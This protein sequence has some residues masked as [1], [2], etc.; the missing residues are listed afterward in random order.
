MTTFNHVST[1]SRRPDGAFE[2]EIPPEWMQGRAAFGGLV[3]AAAVRALVDA[4]GPGRPLRSFSLSF[5]APVGPGPTIARPT[6]LRAGRA[7]T[8]GEVRVEQ[9]GQLCAVVL[10]AFGQD[11]PSDLALP[12]LHTTPPSPPEATVDLP[13]IEG[14]MP[15]FVS[16]F[17]LRWADGAPP[18]SGA[19]TAEFGGWCRHTTDAPGLPG[20]IGLLDAWP[21][22]VLPMLR[23]PAPASTARWTAHIVTD[24]AAAPTGAWYWYTSRALSAGAGYASTLNHLYDA[25]GALV[26]WSEQLVVIFDR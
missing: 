21:A 26:A 9:G 17:Q 10:A 6:V 18:F 15:R 11:R 24:T 1:W 14:V 2:G 7:L 13:Y 19:P 25:T 5:V 23:H 16:N 20:V 12:R 8:H 4:V 22:P 3:A